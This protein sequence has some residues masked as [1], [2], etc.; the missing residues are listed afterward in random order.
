MDVDRWIRN[1][2]S[3][4]RIPAPTFREDQRAE[5]MYNSFLSNGLDTVEMDAAGNVYGRVA[6]GD[7]PPVIL[8]AHLDTVF[9]AEEM[10][11]ATLHDGVLRGPGVGDNAI[12]LAALF[13]LAID[14]PQLEP[15]GDVWLVATVAE[16][17]LGNLLGMQ[18][19]VERFGDRV[20]AYIALEGMSLGYVYNR[21]LPVRRFRISAQTGGGHSWIHA[22]RPSA[23][24]SLVDLVHELA[25][26]PNSEGARTSLNVGLIEGGT[27]V[28][29]IASLAVAEL[30]LRAESED[31]LRELVDRVEE[32]VKRHQ[33]DDVMIRLEAIGHRPG[34]GLP[35]DHP[36]VAAAKTAA[37]RAGMREPSLQTGSTDASLP[38]SL[39]LP[40]V[41]V[42]LTRGGDAHTHA[43]F[44][45]VAPLAQG[46]EALLHLVE[47]SFSLDV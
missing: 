36:L 35:A 16:E 12:A 20:S 42:G 38:L 2:L 41:C 23:I 44:I 7:R 39:G 21:A 28:N 18:H 40:A 24:H 1:T 14:L 13:E 22:G 27:S 37:Q 3:L 19:V 31:S 11:A 4:Q 45:E 17:G 15:R 10:E 29:T 6:G 9:S 25:I 8:S 5:I 33:T 46:Y 47:S 43:E 34:G 32:A 30:D 26:L